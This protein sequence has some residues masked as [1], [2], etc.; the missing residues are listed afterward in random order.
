MRT[1]AVY[2]DADRAA[3]HVRE[4]DDSRPARTRRPPA[5]RT[6]ASTRSS[7]AAKDTGAGLVH[8][9]YGF[10]SENTDFARA[11]RGGRHRVRRAD[12]RADR[13]RSA[14]S[15]P[16]ASWPPRPGC[17]CSPAPGCSP[18]VDDAVAEAE[19]IGL[20][21]ML[22]ATGGGGGI[23]MQACAHPR[24][25]PRGL[26]ERRPPREPRTS[27]RP[28]S[29]SS[30]CVRP[31]RHVEVQL[32]GDGEG[33]VAVIGDRDC[34][35]Q[36]RNQKVIEE[37]P[38]PALPE[39]VRAEL[40]A[41]ARRLA[42]SVGY[43]SAGTVEFVYDPVREEASFLEVNTRL[44]VEH[45]V[46]EEVLRRRPRR[47]H[48]PAGPRRCRR[49]RPATCSTA[50]WTP[51]GHAVEA[52]VYAEDPAKG[53]LPSSG[54]V[55]QAV[56]PARRRHPARAPASASTAGSRPAPRCRRSTTRCSPR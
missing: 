44:Q 27:G 36:R 22:K 46:T 5:S 23:G 43:R 10:L 56:F 51:N 6:C 15:T 7:Q 31:A 28:A 13:P 21:V 30:G 35:L 33:R 20:P 37:A 29:S 12:R 8:P 1:V 54:L 47:A 40:H 24:R 45:P 2:S 14:R 53:S 39:H 41:S 18:R 32:F 26:R 42:E 17:R 49:H 55:T 11:C 50:R 4:A 3:P 38:A 19:R 9:G 34:S 16:P 48:A 25:G 52:R